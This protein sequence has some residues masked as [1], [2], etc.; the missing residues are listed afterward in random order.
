MAAGQREQPGNID[1]KL[2][3][4]RH[5]AIDTK[6]GRRRE[7]IQGEMYQVEMYRME[8]GRAAHGKLGVKFGESSSEKVECGRGSGGSS[9]P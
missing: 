8:K 5:R 2:K 1:R 3:K 9:P 4:W 6:R 7:E